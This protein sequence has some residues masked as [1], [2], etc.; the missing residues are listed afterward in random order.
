MLECATVVHL[1]EVLDS[2]GTY[3]G[4]SVRVLGLLKDVDVHAFE[5]TLEN[6][7]EVLRIGTEMLLGTFLERGSWYQ[8]IGEVDCS[9]VEGPVLVA[10]VA[11]NVNGIDPQLFDEALQL[12]RRFLEQRA[13]C[14]SPTHSAG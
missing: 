5:A 11:R 2:P 12:R 8:I 10:R 7:G 4:K 9:S 3:S 13:P 14:T 6:H 1:E